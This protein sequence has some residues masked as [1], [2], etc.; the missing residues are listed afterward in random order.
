M[1]ENKVVRF[2]RRQWDWVTEKIEDVVI[3]LQIRARLVLSRAKLALVD[4]RGIGTVEVILILVVLIAILFVFKDKLK[5]LV[6]AIFKK[7][8]SESS[9][10]SDKL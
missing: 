8:T 10:L 6:D 1:R 3:W 2:M 4:E 5:A 7:I 9:G